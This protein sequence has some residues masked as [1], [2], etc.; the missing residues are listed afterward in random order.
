M[1]GQKT[2]KPG[3]IQ[4]ETEFEKLTYPAC[5]ALSWMLCWIILFLEALTRPFER[6]LDKLNKR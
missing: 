1:S 2:I 4:P 5:D 6:M 3:A